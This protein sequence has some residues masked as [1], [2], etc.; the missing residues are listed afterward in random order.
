VNSLGVAKAI[1]LETWRGDTGDNSL[2]A[3]SNLR[4]THEGRP[5]TQARLLHV[6][7]GSEYRNGSR[8]FEI[9]CKSPSEE[10]RRRSQPSSSTFVVVDEGAVSRKALPY[11]GGFLDQVGVITGLRREESSFEATLDP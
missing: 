6:V 5:G 7:W 1:N 10:N 4:R 2:F 11:S 8:L 3:D 9:L